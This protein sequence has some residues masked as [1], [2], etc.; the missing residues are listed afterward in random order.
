MILHSR[1]RS[2]YR[3]ATAEVKRGLAGCHSRNLLPP[4]G[5]YNQR[6]HPIP[7]P[8]RPS[9][10]LEVQKWHSPRRAAAAECLAGCPLSSSLLLLRDGCATGCA[11]DNRLVRPCLRPNGSPRTKYTAFFLLFKTHNSQSLQASNFQAGTWVCCQ[12]GCV[13]CGVYVE[14]ERHLPS[15]EPT[16]VN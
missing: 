11:V 14:N 3:T 9:P 1:P 15:Q 2:S 7:S 5:Q 10:P 4:C 12:L 6:L 16:A 13:G 8:P